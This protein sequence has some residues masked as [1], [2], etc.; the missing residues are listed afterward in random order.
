MKQLRIILHTLLFLCILFNIRVFCPSVGLSIGPSVHQKVP[1][2]AF[3]AITPPPK[4]R[5]IRFRTTNVNSYLN[6]T[7]QDYTSGCNANIIHSVTLFPLHLSTRWFTLEAEIILL[8]PLTSTP[9]G[10]ETVK[11]FRPTMVPP[12]SG[13]SHHVMKL[14]FFSRG[15]SSLDCSLSLGQKY[16]RFLLDLR[17]RQNSGKANQ[18]IFGI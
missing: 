6:V 8:G 9:F 16:R 4:P 14:V 15:F 13:A 12:S 1:D 5:L 17:W 11:A 18:L 10:P 3:Y 7:F 2:L